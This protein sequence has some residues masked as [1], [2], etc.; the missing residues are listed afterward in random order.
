MKAI[1]AVATVVLMV[2]IVHAARAALIQDHRPFMR[3]IDPAD[4][5][6]LERENEVS[7]SA[8]SELVI[9]A[10]VEGRITSALTLVGGGEE[11][12]LKRVEVAKGVP[13]TGIMVERTVFPAAI[14]N[15]VIESIKSIMEYQV[16][17]PE[18]PQRADSSNQWGNE[19]WICL[20]VAPTQVIAGRVSGY[21]MHH[22]EGDRAERFHW[23]VR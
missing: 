9:Y 15:R 6:L 18:D 11:Y 4:F 7:F 2:G 10:L 21:T 22:P 14:A 17:S 5:L 13:K 3:R 20:R 1:R 16:L 19:R 23:I 8:S 12:S